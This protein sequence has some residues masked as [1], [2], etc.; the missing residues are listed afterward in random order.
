M[1]LDTSVLHQ[2]KNTEK[3]KRYDEYMYFTVGG[4]KAKS[5]LSLSP[6]NL[7]RMLGI[8]LKNSVKTLDAITHQ[9]IRS[10]G[11]LANNFKTDKTQLQ[12]K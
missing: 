4:V 10:T 8:R 11:L 2:S 6:D 3:N 12:Y 1:I 5:L 7:S 9:C